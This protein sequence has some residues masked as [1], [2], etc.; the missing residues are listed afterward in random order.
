MSRNTFYKWLKRYEKD[1]LAGLY[2]KPKAP[3]N[4]RKPTIRNKCKE[5]VDKALYNL[6]P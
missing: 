5:R 2:D 1:G 3:V 6:R 4:T